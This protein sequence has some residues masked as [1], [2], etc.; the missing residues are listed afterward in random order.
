[1]ALDRHRLPDRRPSETVTVDRNG[2]RI[3]VSAGYCPKTGQL[4]EIFVAGGKEGSE[5]RHVLEDA[6]VLVSIGLQHGIPLDVMRHSLSR[7]PAGPV[8]PGD[9]DKSPRTVA[10]S[11][12]GL[13]LDAAADLS[14]EVN[15]EPENHDV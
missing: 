15:P 13:A 8:L 10:A 11:L 14:P 1:M 9:L 6:A 2:I 12:I 5:T 4:L 3:A 7:V